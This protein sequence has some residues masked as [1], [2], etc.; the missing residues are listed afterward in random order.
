MLYPEVN[1]NIILADIEQSVVGAMRLLTGGRIVALIQN[2]RIAQM[3]ERVKK[4]RYMDAINK[5]AVNIGVI[6]M[7][8][9]CIVSCKKNS[10][11]V[12]PAITI[13]V[14]SQTEEIN[15]LTD[16]IAAIEV[17]PLNPYN[18]V[19]A[20]TKA[21]NT[22]D[23]TLYLTDGTSL[24]RISPDGDVSSAGIFRGRAGNEYLSITDF[25]IK[26][27][28]LS[29]LDGRK[30]HR[31]SITDISSH[32]SIKI[33]ADVPFDALAPSNDDGYFL[34]SAFAKKYKD[35]SKQKDDLLYV[36]NSDGKTVETMLHREDN[37]V[38]IFN[39]SQSSGNRY[40]LRPQDSKNIF[41]S[42]SEGSAIPEYGLNFGDKNIPER[43]FFNE[44]AGDL[45]LYMTAPYYKMPLDCYEAGSH[46]YFH[47]AGPG[48][49]DWMM[50]FD[51]NN[52]RGIR[53]C[54]KMEDGDIRIL[55][56]D[57]KSF[58][59]IPSIGMATGDNGPLFNYLIS[60]IEESQLHGNSLVKLTF[61]FLEL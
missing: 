47:F 45:G 4:S 12:N 59:L 19:F 6:L 50:V 53:W 1:R 27:D 44:A 24:I 31:Y 48:A 25:C 14:F 39:I 46:T 36:V 37:T 40:F 8:L 16:F 51:K 55:S 61:K 60:H 29:I 5:V 22:G 13:D 28:I 20:P 33:K 18:L 35:N 49:S 32:S 56:S 3:R 34:F 23:G 41:Y 54:N 7:T 11:P 57:D 42:L 10:A 43:Y 9:S 2:G 26:D 17:I 30:I 21:L 52:H 38:S 58:F 15:T